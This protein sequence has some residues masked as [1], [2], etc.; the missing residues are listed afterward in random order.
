MK[1]LNYYVLIAVLF[2]FGCNKEE[3]NPDQ[4]VTDINGLN[5]E[6][7]QVISEISMDGKVLTFIERDGNVG[8]LERYLPGEQPILTEDFEGLTFSEI[9]KK[10]APEREVPEILG[11]IEERFEFESE[12]EAK[13]Q[14]QQIIEGNHIEEK[15]VSNTREAGLN[16]VWFRDNYCNVSSFWNGYKAC[17]L[18]RYG[19]GTD[20]AWANCS[21]SRVYVYP[22]QGGQV[23]LRGQV[24]GSTLFDADLLSGYVYSYYMFSGKNFWG[25]RQIKKH[26]YS[27]TNTSG[28]GW[29]WNLRSNTNC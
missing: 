13:Y 3:H 29:H 1:N 27:I 2:A 17:L 6:G 19:P 4:R 28:D 7:Q 21:R 25:C 22:F 14:N 11:Q 5:Q 10:L 24:N 26:Y 18:N 16:D 9:H 8:V 12:V 15:S 23:H 20:W